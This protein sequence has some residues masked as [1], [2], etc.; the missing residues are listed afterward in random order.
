MTG[1]VSSSLHRTLISGGGTSD[2]ELRCLPILRESLRWAPPLA[3]LAWPIRVCAGKRLSKSARKSSRQDLASLD[4][5][6]GKGA[7]KRKGS[8]SSGQA[9]TG[10]EAAQAVLSRGGGSRGE[11]DIAPAA[12]G[13]R[14][15]KGTNQRGAGAQQV[16]NQI[17]M[18]GLVCTRMP[19]LPPHPTC[20]DRSLT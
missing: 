9:A 19:L 6:A 13:L 5:N 18:H 10:A 14:Q 3:C 4:G 8:K 7:A 11:D 15:R 1:V 16:I 20:D 2:R 12:D 17:V